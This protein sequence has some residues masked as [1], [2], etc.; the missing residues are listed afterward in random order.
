MM[1]HT[2]KALHTQVIFID[3]LDLRKYP[4]ETISLPISFQAN[5]PDGT[6]EYKI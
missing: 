6:L 2:I 4:F 5:D 1:S 3:E